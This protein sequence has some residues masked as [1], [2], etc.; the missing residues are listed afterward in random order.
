[1]IFCLLK[2]FLAFFVFLYTFI[3]FFHTKYEGGFMK[4]QL[5][6][7]HL[8]RDFKKT[9]EPVGKISKKHKKL[10]FVVQHHLAR[11][12]H[13]DFRLEWNGTLKSWAVPKGPSYKTDDKR[14]AVLVEDHPISYRN[15]E[16]VIPKGQYGGGTVMIFDEGYYEPVGNFKNDFKKGFIKFIL[17][18]KR[19]KGRWTFVHFKEDNWLLIKEKDGISGFLDIH[20]FNTSVKTGRTMEE[21]ALNKDKRKMK[22]SKKNSMIGDTLITHPEKVIFKRPKITKWDIAL[23]YQKVSSRMLPFLENRIISTIRVPDGIL[24]K[25]FFKKHLNNE[26]DGIGRVDI[27]SKKGKKED[28]Y[29]IKN[30]NGLLSEVQ[31]NSYEFHVWGSSV[32]KLEQPTMMVFDLD[33][34]EKMSLKKVRQGVK[35]LKSILDELSLVSF[36]KTSGGKGYHVVLP[37]SSLKTW[38][39]FRD[40]A[41]NIAKL[42]EAK[43]PE[44]YVSNVRKQKRK[45][46]IF[47]DWIR[48]TKGATSVAPYSIRTRKN[49][50]VSMPISWT[51]LD[52][53]RPNE[54]TM[55]KAILRL[56][57]KNPWENFFSVSQ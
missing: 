23:Y 49:A 33:P 27:P 10:S 11:K 5:N 15:F 2:F 34:D 1:M 24:K 8:K 28:Y 41:K 36:L 7:Y 57:R 12:E 3:V 26:N 30:V 18:G 4:E 21:I 53:V 31:Q 17:K 43:W 16:G 44:R 45:N 50:P 13:Y 56:K 42:M 35:D 39:E 29:Y 47:I 22:I 37:I 51:E 48:N 38:D 6:Q 52:R 40:F 46:K 55:D 54:I 32:S 20:E 9:S 19:L 14:L 25:R